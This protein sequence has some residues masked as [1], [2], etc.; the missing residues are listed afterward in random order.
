M[1]TVLLLHLTGAA[2]VWDVKHG[3]IP[4]WLI[5]AGLLCGLAYQWS[6]F[7]AAGLVIY[8]TGVLLPVTVLGILFYFRMMGA[9]DVK[10][11]G[12]I[13]GF[14]GPADGFRSMICAFLIGGLISAILLIKRRNLYWRFFY[15][16]TYFSQF[17]ETKQWRPYRR[18]EDEDSHLYF[19]I[20]IFLSLLCWMGG[21]Y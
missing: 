2:V 19:S 4:N 20:P 18:A 8:V 6:C 12:V 11:L 13:G 16:K 7:R 1:Q 17:L 15:F 9:G 5:A 14:L 21:I 3:K 10:L